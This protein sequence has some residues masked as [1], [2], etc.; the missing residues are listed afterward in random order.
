MDRERLDA[1]VAELHSVE[2]KLKEQDTKK[3]L[4]VGLG[5]VAAIVAIAAICYG[6]YCYFSP[7]Y[8]DDDD[9]DFDFEDDYEDDFEAE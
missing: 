6:V 8:L 9:D 2:A 3:V 1:I 5:V 4:L 7:D